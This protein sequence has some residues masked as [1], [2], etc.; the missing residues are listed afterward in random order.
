MAFVI[1]NLVPLLHGTGGNTLWQYSSVGDSTATVAGAGYFD[2][3]YIDKILKDGDVII[4]NPASGVGGVIR[5][6]VA[7]DGD[8]TPAEILTMDAA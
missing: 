1:G 5:I 4:N 8:L 7:G 6:T 2:Q 3:A